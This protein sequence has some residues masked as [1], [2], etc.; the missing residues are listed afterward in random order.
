M[1]RRSREYQL[2][3]TSANEIRFYKKHTE[4]LLQFHW[5]YYAE[6]A[7]Q[8]RRILEQLQES[9]LKNCS[10]EPFVFDDWQRAVKFKYSLDPLSVK[11]SLSDPGGRFNIGAI[12]TTRF[13]PFPALYLASDKDTALQELL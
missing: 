6:L 12:D 9:L 8:R 5:Q 7:Y 3:R 10:P 4:E 11:G 1:A 13:P 2:D